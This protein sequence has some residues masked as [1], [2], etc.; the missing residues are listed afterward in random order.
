M[1]SPLISSRKRYQAGGDDPH[2]LAEALLQEAR[3][4]SPQA[5]T[6]ASSLL[7]QPA[8]IAQVEEHRSTKPSAEVRVLL[9]VPR[10]PGRMARLPPAK[11]LQIGSTPMDTSMGNRRRLPTRFQ[12]S[13]RQGSTPWFPAYAASGVCKYEDGAPAF[14]L[15]SP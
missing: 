9:G 13:C 10:C 3:L 14:G 5:S 4:M 15:G 12:T 8:P 1:T 11:R 2:A 7:A 6:R